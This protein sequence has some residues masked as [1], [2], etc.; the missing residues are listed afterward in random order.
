LPPLFKRHLAGHMQVRIFFKAASLRGQPFICIKKGIH[1][2]LLKVHSLTDTSHDRQ[3]NAALL[4]M[5]MRREKP[6][7]PGGVS[8]A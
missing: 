7:L 5:A 3:A 8:S 1:H 4:F 2:R 6:T